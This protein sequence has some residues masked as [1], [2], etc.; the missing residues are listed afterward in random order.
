MAEPKKYV[1]KS[2]AKEIQFNDGGSLL[3]LSFDAKELAEFVRQNQNSNGWI[4]LVVSRR[5]E[6]SEKGATHSVYLDAWEPNR[7][8]VQPAPE[9][10]TTQQSNP[11]TTPPLDNANDVPF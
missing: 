6:P 3:K 5:R 8:G 11:A 1:P 2:S 10:R 9:H 4:T 7:R